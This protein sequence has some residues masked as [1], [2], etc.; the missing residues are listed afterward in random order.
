V[1]TC[2][3]RALRFG[4][5]EKLIEQKANTAAAKIIASCN[6]QLLLARFP[7]VGK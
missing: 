3:A 2:P 7:F 6:P 5:I 1:R 4:P